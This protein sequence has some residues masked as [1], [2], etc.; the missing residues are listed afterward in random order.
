MI[1]KNLR[2]S[3]TYFDVSSKEQETLKESSS[4]HSRPECIIHFWLILTNY[5]HQ[6]CPNGCVFLLQV[7]L[8]A[9]MEQDHSS[10]PFFIPTL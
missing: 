6:E 7:K 1:N 3:V 5:G 4:R 9:R 2:Y 8:V 10:N